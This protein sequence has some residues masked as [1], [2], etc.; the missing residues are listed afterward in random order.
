MTNG[1]KSFAIEL[2]DSKQTLGTTVMNYRTNSKE[3]VNKVQGLEET[4][5]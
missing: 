1:L 4:S 5:Y 2:N 3:Q